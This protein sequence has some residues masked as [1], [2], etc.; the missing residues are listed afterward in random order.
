MVNKEMLL[1]AIDEAGVKKTA[2]SKKIGVSHQCFL[3]KI[4]NL[5]D[6]KASEISIIIAFLGLTKEQVDSIFFAA[7]VDNLPTFKNN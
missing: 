3:N 6:F 5:S 4:N 7:N 1:S 2:V